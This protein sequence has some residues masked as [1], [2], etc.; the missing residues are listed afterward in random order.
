V[1]NS[2]E[3]PGL[4]KEAP[5]TT[6]RFSNTK[7]TKRKQPTTTPER[8]KANLVPGLEVIAGRGTLNLA[9]LKKGK[10]P[11]YIS[12]IQVTLR[13]PSGN[14]KD[15][16]MDLLFMGL[17]T[18]RTKDKTVCFVHPTDTSQTA[19]KRQDMPPKFQKIHKDWAEFKAGISRFKNNI[20][21][22]RKQTY[23]LSIW[24]GSNKPTEKILDACTLEWEEDRPNGGRVKMKYKQVQSLYTAKNLILVGV[25]TNIDADSLQ[26]LMLGMMEE[27]R[28]KMV[29]QNQSKYG[30][31]INVPKFVLEKDYIKNTPYAERSDDDDIP[32]WA[33]MPFHLE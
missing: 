28:Q 23:A 12:V 17:D 24:L 27:A 16:V 31:L 29:T 26:N 11:K 30:S 18:L 9:N 10:E 25:P 5:S 13:V 8:P 7:Q 20:K 4:D 19:K 2:L 22:G 6:I 14:V 1:L 32:F 33:R 3:E 21:E 15:L